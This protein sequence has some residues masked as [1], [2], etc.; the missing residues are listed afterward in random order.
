[1]ATPLLE[2]ALRG[3]RELLAALEAPP[4]AEAA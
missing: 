2:A 4:A 1:V 3:G